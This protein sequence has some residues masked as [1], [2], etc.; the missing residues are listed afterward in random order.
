MYIPW[1]T[2]VNTPSLGYN[3]HIVLPVVRYNEG[4]L[5]FYQDSQ[6]RIPWF[7][8]K[9]NAAANNKKKKK[10]VKSEKQ[11]TAA[12]MFLNKCTRRNAVLLK[13][14]L[15]PLRTHFRF[16]MLQNSRQFKSLN[17]SLPNN[18]EP[19]RKCIVS[20]G[21][22]HRYAVY[23]KPRHFGVRLPHQG[24]TRTGDRSPI[25]TPLQPVACEDF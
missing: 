13:M 22:S 3:G 23:K 14:S 2:S 8:Y 9:A 5:Y 7:Y 16:P 12:V 20:G 4:L 21:Q 18:D 24:L 11:R 17:A 19:F 1:C 6:V 10:H 15:P 25:N